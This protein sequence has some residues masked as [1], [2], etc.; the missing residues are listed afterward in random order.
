MPIDAAIVLGAALNPD[1]SPG[2]ALR[3]R[4][5]AGAALVRAGRAPRL[6]LSGG[7]VRHHRSEAEVMHALAL[8]H[9]VPPEALV[10]EPD[11]RNT[12]EN[13]RNC[14]RI[15]AANGWRRVA[16]VTDGYHLPRALYVFRRLGMDAEGVAAARP[17]GR[18]WRVAACVREA[19]AFLLYLPR[20]ERA[21]REP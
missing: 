17:P 20:V 16:V 9:G 12:L 4:V 14:R 10:L 21:R 15:L 18:A 2:P 19:G 1:G 13:A 6:V 8:R 7:A 5:A 11:S 3:R